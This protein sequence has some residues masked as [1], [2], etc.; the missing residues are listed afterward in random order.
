MTQERWFD[1]IGTRSKASLVSLRT[2]RGS[3]RTQRARAAGPYP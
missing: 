3:M 1:F 2:G